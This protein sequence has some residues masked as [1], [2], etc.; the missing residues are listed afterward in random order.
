[1]SLA[2]R[3]RE[4]RLEVSID[5]AVGNEACLRERSDTIAKRMDCL[6]DYQ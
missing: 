5:D 6:L 2:D 3:L 1:M 4:A